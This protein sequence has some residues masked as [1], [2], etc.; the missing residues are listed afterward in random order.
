MSGFELAMHW[1]MLLTLPQ[2]PDWLV[3]VRV[4]CTDSQPPLIPVPQQKLCV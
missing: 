3:A 2:V 1:F 4:F